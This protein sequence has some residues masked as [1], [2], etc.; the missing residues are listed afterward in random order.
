M[1]RELANL[2]SIPEES[3]HRLAAY[4]C[5]LTNWLLAGKTGSATSKELAETL[6]LKETTIRHDLL[7][8]GEAPGTRGVGYNIT[9]LRRMIGEFLNLPAFAPVAIVGSATVINALFSFFPVEKSGFIPAAFFSEVPGDWGAVIN[10]REVRPV[11]EI[12]S[13]L[14][15][16]GV[17]VAIVAAHPSWVQHSV[18]LLAQAGI[19]A[20]LILS[21]SVMPD[22]P[23][24]V[25]AIQVTITC[26]LKTLFFYAS[27]LDHELSEDLSAGAHIG[28]SS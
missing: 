21:Q 20:L 26:D 25:H 6:G 12:S 24:G 8:L 15:A 19:K 11:D 18:N 13:T 22:I 2:K 7:Y 3:L 5:I 14:G 9:V 4:H 27:M 17:K 23:E 16:M 10:G 28:Q 1:A